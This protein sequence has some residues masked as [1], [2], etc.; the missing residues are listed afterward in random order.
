MQNHPFVTSIHRGVSCISVA[1]CL[2]KEGSHHMK[3]MLEQDRFLNGQV[4]NGDSYRYLPDLIAFHSCQGA[5]HISGTMVNGSHGMS[6]WVQRVV[7]PLRSE[8]WERELEAHPDQ[9][10]VDYIV[11]G[12]KMGFRI[13]FN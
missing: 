11:T 6:P 9:V 1:Q 8:V 10:F 7:T 4:K 3:Q 12:I 5:V 13:G 2:G